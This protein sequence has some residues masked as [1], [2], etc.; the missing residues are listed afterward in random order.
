M[1]EVALPDDEREHDQWSKMGEEN[2]GEMNIMW[3][4]KVGW[5]I[6]TK[7]IINDYWA[8]SL[9]KEA[10]SRAHVDVVMSKLYYCWVR[11]LWERMDDGDS[12]RKWSHQ[13]LRSARWATE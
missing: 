6:L 11:Q 3:G 7:S 12:T 10:W 9:S 2:L 8:D 4:E 1:K 13:V 5:D